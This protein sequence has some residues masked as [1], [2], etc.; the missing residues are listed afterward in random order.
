MEKGN[1]LQIVKVKHEVQKEDGD[2]EIKEE[3]LIEWKEPIWQ[4]PLKKPELAV[5][6]DGPLDVQVR[7]GFLQKRAGKSRFRWNIRYF[8]LTDCHLRWW[9]PAFKD[10]CRLR[11]P[12]FMKPGQ[13]RPRPVRSLDLRQLIFVSRTR[14]KFPYSTRILLKFNPEYTDYQLELRSEKEFDILGWYK[15]FTRFQIECEDREVD[16]ASEGETDVPGSAVGEI[17]LASDGSEELPPEPEEV[18]ESPGVP[19]AGDADTSAVG[20]EAEDVDEGLLKKHESLDGQRMDAALGAFL[21]SP[22]HPDMRQA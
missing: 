4:R 18:A 6:R 15:L 1:D 9:R 20:A 12:H 17:D 19:A 7:E 2:W 10:Q 21:E 22:S 5:S 13:K 11:V 8:E 3:E 16:A 14:V